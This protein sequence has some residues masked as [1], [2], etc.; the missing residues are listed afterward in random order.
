MVKQRIKFND[1]E[2]GSGPNIEKNNELVLDEEL[3]I[4]AYWQNPME[5]ITAF[6]YLKS[7]AVIA[8]SAAKDMRDD[9]CRVNYCEHNGGGLIPLVMIDDLTYH[10]D[11]P[12]VADTEEQ[13]SVV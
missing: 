3:M 10:A 8:R 4:P 12:F 7:N 11:G 13:T 2:D 1:G 9:F 5:A 6:V